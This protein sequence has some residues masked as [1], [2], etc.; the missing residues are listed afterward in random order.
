M[1]R[2]EHVEQ[3]AR[4]CIY[5]RS[6]R[7]CM[8]HERTGELCRCAMY[9][10]RS[11]KVLIIQISSAAG[12]IRSSALVERLKGDDP[13]CHITYLSGFPELIDAAVDEPLG[14][15]PGSVLRCQLDTFDVV[16]NLDLDVRACGIVN[17]L[18]A[19]RKKGFYLRQGQPVPLD[20]DSQIGFLRAITPGALA[21]RR[22]H[23]VQEIFSLC[24]LE[25]RHERPRLP[26]GQTICRLVQ[27]DEELVVGLNTYTENRTPAMPYWEA[28]RWIDLIERLIPQGL[29]VMLLGHVGPE[30]FNEQIARESSLEYVK[31]SNWLDVMD[32]VGQ[33]DMV[34]TPAGA[35]CEMAL[36]LD[37]E[38]VLLEDRWASGINSDYLRG[39][40]AIIKPS[41]NG[42]GSLEQISPHRVFE[43]V[44]ERISQFPEQASPTEI[45]NH[46]NAAPLKL[47]EIRDHISRTRRGPEQ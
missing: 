7:P 13:H 31:S 24:G 38:V 10:P 16:Y 20:E 23:P 45:N 43:V 28:Q 11:V 41:G 22:L 37:Q 47:T 40:G 6:D 46:K 21:K 42:N 44:M 25:Y 2:G 14:F 39:R 29:A 4:N 9:A 36:A 26:R 32:S 5:Y 30:R 15:D 3:I 34:V 27:R 33:C 17:I 1:R 12:V 19:Q 18:S 8:P 35:V